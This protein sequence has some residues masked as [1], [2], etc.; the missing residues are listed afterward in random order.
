LYQALSKALG[1]LDQSDMVRGHYVVHFVL[2]QI[3]S[4]CAAIQKTNPSSR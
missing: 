1:H 3:Y 4:G 2:I